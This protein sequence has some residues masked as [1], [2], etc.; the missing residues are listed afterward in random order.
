[1]SKNNKKEERIYRR[2]KRVWWLAHHTLRGAFE[3]TFGCKSY[4]TENIPEP[5]LVLSNHSCDLDP[6]LVGMSFPRHMYFVASEHIYRQG[7]LSKIL[8]YCFGPIAKIKGASDKMMVLK[9]VK[10]LR[11]NKNVCIFPEGN[12]TWTGRNMPVTNAIGKLV[13]VSGA[14]LVTYKL[15]GGFFTNPRWGYGIRKG[16]MEG[17][18]VRVY[19]KEELA[20]MTPEQVTEIIRNDIDENAY[21]RQKE[22]M[23][24]YKGKK[25][26][27]GMECALCVCPQCKKI[28]IIETKDDTVSCKLCGPLAVYNNYG[29]FESKS[30]GFSF[31]TVEEWDDWQEEYYSSLVEEKAATPQE[32]FFADD[33]VS[34]NTVT[35]NHEEGDLGKG[36]LWL[37]SEGL[38]FK[39]DITDLFISIKNLPDMGMYGKKG[40]VFTDEKNVH[41]E[42]HSE[43][44]LNV[45]KY[46]SVWNKLKEKL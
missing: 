5:Y 17:R 16:K 11:E 14:N 29:F 31:K 20:E 19:T 3:N 4:I 37:T 43:K 7:F 39:S 44:L 35:S 1:M 22:E 21:A 10:T 25:L 13:K 38:Y 24:A 15:T 41:Y 33:E 40:L 46:I 30:N 12:R 23:I 42:L 45:R 2:H 26:A 32:I 36:K 6:A 28:D 18:V 34:L 8:L 27:E 9:V